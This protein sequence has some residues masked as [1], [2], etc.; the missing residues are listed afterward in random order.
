M[1]DLLKQK[2]N[3]LMQLSHY[4]QTLGFTHP[5]TVSKSQELDQIVNQI[6]LGDAF[7]QKAG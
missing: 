7:I 2:E 6:V 4:A 1:L 5:K 3:L